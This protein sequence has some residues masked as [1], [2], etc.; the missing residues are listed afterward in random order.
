LFSE[1]RK[2]EEGITSNRRTV[3]YGETFSKLSTHRPSRLGIFYIFKIVGVLKI[4]DLWNLKR[5]VKV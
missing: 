3:R 2:H 5:V 4:Y 1:N